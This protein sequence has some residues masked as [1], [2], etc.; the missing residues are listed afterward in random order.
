MSEGVLIVRDSACVYCSV[1]GAEVNIPTGVSIV[2]V[3]RTAYHIKY[4][5]APATANCNWYRPAKCRT[6]CIPP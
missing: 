4:Q 2:P 1:D 6:R 3:T 5:I